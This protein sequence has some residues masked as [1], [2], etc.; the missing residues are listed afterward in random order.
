[1]AVCLVEQ[2]S[3]RFCAGHVR[4][5]GLAWIRSV[6][7]VEGW[8]APSP[9]CLQSWPP[10]FVYAGFQSKPSFATGILRRGHTQRI[11]YKFNA[12][13]SVPADL[14]ILSSQRRP[15][16]YGRPKLVHT[17]SHRFST[18]RNFTFSFP[19]GN[20][21]NAL[22]QFCTIQIGRPDL[23]HHGIKLV[24]FDC[25][26]PA[27]FFANCRTLTSQEFVF[28]SWRWSLSWFE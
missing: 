25:L 21:E 9:R 1:M 16:I 27:F 11:S 6:V 10:T 26:T 7:G 24:S 17:C 12:Y 28:I 18:K 5:E 4:T 19:I 2:S 15:R 20:E 8:I 3:Y 13:I 14:Q 23:E 22:N